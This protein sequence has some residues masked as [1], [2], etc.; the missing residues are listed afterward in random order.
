M[1]GGTVRAGC[2]VVGLVQDGRTVKG[3]ILET[4][5]EIKADLV[6]VSLPVLSWVRM[7]KYSRWLPAL[8]MFM[9]VTGST[10]LTLCRTPK[11]FASPQVSALLPPIIATG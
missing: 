5:E 9:N 10:S 1:H 8:G 7:L 4:G 11:L 3:V 2:E 6:V